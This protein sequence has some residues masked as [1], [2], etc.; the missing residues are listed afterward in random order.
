MEVGLFN[1]RFQGSGGE[2]FEILARLG[3]KQIYQSS[4]LV[5]DHIYDDF[6]PRMRKVFKRSQ[7]YLEVAAFNS[8]F[9]TRL[10]AIGIMRSLFTALV[11]CFLLLGIILD[12][13]WLIGCIICLI[14]SALSDGGRQLNYLRVHGGLVV[15]ASAMLFIYCEYSA[16]QLGMVLAYWQRRKRHA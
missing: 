16:A 12:L 10:R 14:L 1:T 15:S 6:W 9:P 13:E 5:A 11:T 7:H 2:E 8:G 4:E 3:N